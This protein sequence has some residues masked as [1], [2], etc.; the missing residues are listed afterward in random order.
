MPKP[1]FRENNLVSIINENI[2]LLKELDNSINIIFV[3]HSDKI[4]LQSDKEQISRVFLNL[5]KNSI[6]SINQKA[7]NNNNF[8][9]KVT[10]ELI[11]DDSHIKIAIE[12][13]GVGFSDLKGNIKDI[14]IPYFTTKKNGTGLGLSIVNKIVNDH[15]GKIDFKPIKDGAKIDIIFLK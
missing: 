11:Q 9:K 2:K 4:L 13:N 6:E 1:I 15:N 12:D 14:L 7:Q 3:K 5:I 10:I 8:N